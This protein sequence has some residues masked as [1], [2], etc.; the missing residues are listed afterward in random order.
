MMRTILKSKLHN[1]RITG[2]NLRYMGS[3]TIPGDLMEKADILENERVQ[4]VNLNTGSRLETYVIAGERESG[5]ILLN[6]P[7]ARLGQAGDTVHILTYAL[8][9]DGDCAAFSPRVLILD[10]NNEV[11][12]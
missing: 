10:E 2:A 4:V 7:A 12:G 5:E 11:I 9:G 8:M 6:G 1:A 3:I